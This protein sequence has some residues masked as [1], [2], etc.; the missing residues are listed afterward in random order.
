MYASETKQ[1]RPL[2]LVLT[3]LDT[4][5][6]D[7]D[8]EWLPAVSARFATP[9]I[10]WGRN[11]WDCWDTEGGLANQAL[12]LAT[13]QVLQDKTNSINV[14]PGLQFGYILMK[15]SVCVPPGIINRD[16]WTAVFEISP[17]DPT[18]CL[19]P[20]PIWDSGCSVIWDFPVLFK[21]ECW[22][23]PSLMMYSLLFLFLFC[24]NV[25]I[26]KVS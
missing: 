21:S 22:T 20:F 2:T 6:T 19:G 8:C 4:A 23:K 12:D 18:H 1:S 16:P 25:C 13:F 26:L 11:L 24:F 3:C 15:I 7:S 10:R 9:W 17:M 5:L 14:K